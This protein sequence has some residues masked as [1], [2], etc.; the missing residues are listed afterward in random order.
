MATLATVYSVNPFVRTAEHV[1]D[2]S[3]REPTAEPAPKRPK[4]V[5][6]VVVGRLT[7]LDDEGQP[8]PGE[9]QAFAWAD[10][11]MQRRHQSGNRWCA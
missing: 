2:A 9:V 11:R 10:E 3:F 7:R 6:K 5:G 8:L 1:V 4:P